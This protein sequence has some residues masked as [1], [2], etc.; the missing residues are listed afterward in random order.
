[1]SSLRGGL[2]LKTDLNERV[3]PL[4]LKHM[5]ESADF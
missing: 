2:G 3:S 4:H 5:V 1:V